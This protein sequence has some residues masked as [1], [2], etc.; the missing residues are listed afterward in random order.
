MRVLFSFSFDENQHKQMKYYFYH[1]LSWPQLLWVA[2]DY[3]SKIVGYVLAKMEEDD[4]VPPHGHITSL[5]VLRTHRKRGIATSLMRRSQLEMEQVFG[6]KYVSL[7]V[8]KS[9]RAAFHLYTK[10]LRYEI[11]DVERG[12]YADG[13]D[14][15]D[16]RC[17]FEK[18]RKEAEAGDQKVEGNEVMMDE[19][20]KDGVDVVNDV[21]KGVQEVAVSG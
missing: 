11:H 6:A 15:Y 9:N 13:E 18:Q 19:G 2:E 14:A 8:R 4:K 10:T 20:V 17:V 7:H 3:D 12:Y 1:L 21:T 16:M 5:A